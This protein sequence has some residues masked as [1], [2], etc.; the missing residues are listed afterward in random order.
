MTKFATGQ[1]SSYHSSNTTNNF[2]FGVVV[3]NTDSN[4]G[5]RIKVRIKGI[6]DKITDVNKLSWCNPVIPKF[7]NIVPKIGETVFILV[8]DST[9]LFENRV[10][11][12]PII[13]QP[14]KLEKDPHFYSSMSLFDTGFTE[15][16]QSP[17]TLPKAKG[18]YPNT[19]DIALQGRKNTDI[20]FKDNQV[21]IRAGKHELNDNLIFNET[22]PAFIQLNF[23][24]EIDKDAKRG[25]VINIVSDKINLLTHAGGKPNYN[26]SDKKKMISEE[27]LKRIMDSAHP[28]PFGDELVNFLT[29]IK[30]Y[31]ATHVHPYHGMPSDK[32]KNVKDILNYDLNRLI[33]N[34]IKIN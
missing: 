11:I 26:L 23:D 27:E 8:P 17:S 10:Y 24:A 28:L 1:K 22:N 4:D 20:I 18:V 29:L 15:P 7:I 16:E 5:N 34:N 19:E 31:I 32:N 14:Q 9:N 3:N 25:S 30:E 21:L 6:D 12:G 33:S 2:F 13:S